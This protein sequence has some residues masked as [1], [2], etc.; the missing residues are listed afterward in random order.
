[1]DGWNWFKD[2]KLQLVNLVGSVCSIVAFAILIIGTL[3]GESALPPE[4]RVWQYI[5][6]ATSIVFIFS[7]I[8]FTFFW[9]SEG[10]SKQRNTSLNILIASIKIL[11]GLMGVGVGFD[12]LVSAIYWTWVLRAPLGLLWSVVRNSH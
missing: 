7:V 5:F 4:V 10:F 1:L 8:V 9:I 3:S 6:F 12:A 11:V 2:K